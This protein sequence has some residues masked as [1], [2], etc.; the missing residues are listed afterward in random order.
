MPHIFQ[1]EISC[2]LENE[3][4]YLQIN[5][6][7]QKTAK[8]IEIKC[9]ELL[10]MGC[11]TLIIDIRNTIY[12]LIE[13]G[14]TA[15]ELFLPKG[16]IIGKL[17]RSKSSGD[18]TYYSNSGK[19]K[20]FKLI[21][22]VNSYTRLG[23]EV[24]ASALKENQRAIL[25]GSKTAGDGS[26]IMGYKINDSCSLALVTGYYVS[27]L[28]KIIENNGISPDTICEEPKQY[29]D[30]RFPKDC[31]LDSVSLRDQQ[32]HRAIEIARQNIKAN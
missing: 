6:F 9:D 2:I 28:G 16:T 25:I 15:S 5:N 7:G 29:V 32:L 18:S 13:A 30:V 12:G 8:E 1:N 4:G 11:Q 27:S 10:N 3:I 24:F 21:I 17:R 22:L 20:K 26:H 23:A 31:I 14:K 19:F